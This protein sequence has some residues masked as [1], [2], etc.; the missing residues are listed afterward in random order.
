M[1]G[2]NAS[3]KSPLGLAMFDI[4]ATLTDNYVER[5]QYQNFKK[6]YSDDELVYFEYVF[7]LTTK[8]S[9]TR[10]AKTAKAT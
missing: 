10:T 7:L 5:Y 9:F 1:Y 2:N 4:V 8:M 6:L 3:G